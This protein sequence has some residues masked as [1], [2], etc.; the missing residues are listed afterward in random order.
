MTVDAR[1]TGYVFEAL[2]IGATASMARTLTQADLAIFASVSGDV[3]PQHL[4]ENFAAT[5]VFGQRIAHGMWCGALISAV[6]GTHLPGPGCIYLSQSLRWWRPVVP[7]DTVTANVAV[8]A[9][10]HIKRRVTLACT[11]VNQT[12]ELVALGDAV[13]IPPTAPVNVARPTLPIVTVECVRYQGPAEL[14]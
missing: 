10:D 6:L 13:V 3:N 12:G 11:V 9:K 5:S 8:A 14:V 4:D 7:G 2:D 1:L